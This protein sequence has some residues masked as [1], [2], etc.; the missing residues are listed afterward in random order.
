M[1]DLEIR[2]ATTAD[3]DAVL[4]FWRIAAEGTS[5]TDDHDGVGRLIARDPEAL[6]LALGDGLIIGSVIAGYDG[7][8]CS[9]YRLAVHPDRRR[10]GI[11][12]TLMTA[13]ERRFAA[14]GGRRVDA[15]VLESNTRA[16]HA[17]GSADYHREDH[18]RRWVKTL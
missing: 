9:A 11:A 16:H 18:W 15:M 6:I 17:W 10:Q 3:I 1:N 12:T 7:W 14:L 5:I 8:R 13:A 2:R 4:D